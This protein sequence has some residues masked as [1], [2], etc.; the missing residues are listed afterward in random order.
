MNLPSEKLQNKFSPCKRQQDGMKINLSCRR[1]QIKIK[2]FTL[3]KA[4]R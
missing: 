3:L 2:M 1:G 4:A